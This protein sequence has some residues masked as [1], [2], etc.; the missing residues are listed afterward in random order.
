M[1]NRRLGY[2]LLA[3]SLQYFVV[4][5]WA[6][7]RWPHPYRWGED[8]ISDLGNTVCGTYQGRDVC[9]PLHALMNGSFIVLGITMILGSLL[10]LKRSPVGFGLYGA[11]GVGT[12]LVGLAPENINGSLHFVG[13]G[14][15]FVCGNLALL[16]LGLGKIPWRGLAL[17]LGLLGLDSLLLFANGV[18][19]GLGYGGMERVVAYPQTV[20]AVVFGV[21]G[22]V[23][24]DFT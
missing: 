15:A 3:L 22:L 8:A 1:P 9:S 17:G 5:G 14:L 2:L 18:Y 7:S 4:Q 19:L 6:A 24:R 10:L 11:A 16:V 21:Y 13:A 20:W 23:K 12:I